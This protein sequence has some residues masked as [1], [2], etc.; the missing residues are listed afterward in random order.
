MSK[1]PFP[2]AFGLVTL[3]LLGS[4]ATRVPVSEAPGCPSQALVAQAASRYLALQPETN[5]PAEWSPAAAACG[6]AK[7]VQSLQPA[8]GPVVGWKAGLTNAAMQQRF[9]VNQPVRGTLLQSM[10]LEDGAQVPAKFGVRPF[11]EAD[12]LV[13][14][15]S[16]AIHEATTP[17]EVLRSLRAVIPFIELPDVNLADPSR[18]NG[19]AITWI[20]VG[21]RFGVRGAPIA[22]RADA[23]YVAALRS[24]R[25][26]V[27][28][29]SG[30]ELDAAQGD[31][32]LGHPLNA[33]LWLAA[34]LK[35]SGITLRPGD[36]LSLGSFSRPLPAASGASARVSYEGLPGDPSVSVNF[37]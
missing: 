6:Q 16:P 27:T 26:R 5:P 25:V 31:V 8:M 36:L 13:E 18:V 7:F 35:R 20:N 4:C 3:A 30:R 37:R 22:V 21:A 14:V 2:M 33:V 11:L 24:M 23:E 15:A 9:G 12:L 29:G 19:A 17:L 10:M 32:I 1:H 34:D 28:D